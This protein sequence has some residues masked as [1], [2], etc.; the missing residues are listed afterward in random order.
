MNKFWKKYNK[1]FWGIDGYYDEHKK[2]ILDE[3]GNHAYMLTVSFGLINNFIA[4]LLLNISLKVAFAYL[5]GTNMILGFLIMVYNLYRIRKSK[6]LSI[7]TETEN[8]GKTISNI[9]QI[10]LKSSFLFL[11]GMLIVSLLLHLTAPA[12][13]NTLAEFFQ[14]NTLIRLIISAFIFGFLIRAYMVR[15]VKIFDEE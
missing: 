1:H 13:H 2:A 3:V 7:E 4:L 9:N 8:K 11:I 6:V 10:A 14:I 15:N 5:M 12:P